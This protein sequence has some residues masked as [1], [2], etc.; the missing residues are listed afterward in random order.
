MDDDL[1]CGQVSACTR[2]L[3][4]GPPEQSFRVYERV[5][6]ANR[7]ASNRGGGNWAYR[8]QRKRWVALLMDVVRSGKATRAEGQRV[9][10]I[11]REYGKGC[12]PWDYGNFV[13]GLK[14]V[15]DALTREVRDG[16]GRGR[17]IPASGIVVDDSEKWMLAEYEQR[18][19]EVDALLFE[20]WEAPQGA[21]SKG[22]LDDATLQKPR[23]TRATKNKPR[24]AGSNGP[25]GDP[26]MAG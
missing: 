8:A 25:M 1:G 6:S 26:G 7:S 19:A 13:G 18:R 2:C 14:P 22:E 12:R 3:G 21:T 17:T 9:V 24:K 5:S 4:L 23:A 11:T 15:I 16:R 20:I 10:R